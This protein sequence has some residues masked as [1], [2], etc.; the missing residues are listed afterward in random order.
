MRSF[1]AA[2]FLFCGF[3][4]LA[5]E[6][7]DYYRALKDIREENAVLA[8]VQAEIEKAGERADSGDFSDFAEGHSFSRIVRT[9]LSGASP[10]T[11]IV[12]A[13]AVCGGGGFSAAVAL[14]L[15]RE[16]RKAP[17]PLN[18]VFLFLGGEGEGASP[19]AD[20]G[21]NFPGGDHLGSRLFLD[22]FFSEYP[23]S[24]LYLNF[25]ELP[26][27]I[28]CET[29]TRGVVAPSWMLENAGAALEDSG[30]PYLIEGSKNRIYRLGLAQSLSPAGEYLSA[31]FPAL[32]LSGEGGAAA[33]D[34]GDYT[35]WGNAFQV[36]FR[37]YLPRCAD[38]FLREWDQHYL[39]LHYGSAYRIIG[40]P[41]LVLALVC[42]LGISLLYAFFAG[43]RLKRSAGIFL[44][45]IWNLP[46]ILFVSVL[47]FMAGTT[48]VRFTDALR[49]TGELWSHHPFIFFILK[50]SCAVFLILLSLHHLRRLPLS[51]RGSFYSVSA[52]FCFLVNVFLSSALD[53]TFIPFFLWSYTASV[54]FS[55]FRRPLVKIILFFTALLP[56]CIPVYDTFFVAEKD[57][58]GFVINSPFLG[59]LLLSSVFLPFILMLIRID[60]LLWHPGKAG[61]GRV[62]KT[63]CVVTG[64]ASVAAFVFALA[65]NPWK[66]SPQPLFLE[67]YVETAQSL[68]GLRLSSPSPLGRFDLSFGGENFPI[69][70]GERV[71]ELPLE[72]SGDQ[73]LGTQGSG[74]QASGEPLPHRI[75]SE[76][77]LGRKT[78][79]ILFS[80]PLKPRK[81]TVHLSCD[82]P[83]LVYNCNFPYSP[84]ITG[85]AAEVFI[86]ENPPL[87][88]RLILTF[89]ARQAVNIRLSSWSPLLSAAGGTEGKSFALESYSKLV[90]SFIIETDE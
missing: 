79:T 32:G 72:V 67:E 65:F 20:N 71:F 47:F 62:L 80:P 85:R 61:S 66:E 68:H 58:A 27:R 16:S 39:F 44:R 82:S 60:F 63:L 46:L 42:V 28:L 5:A 36:F 81:I 48:L 2:C 4:F 17:A 90:D 55:I 37:S 18:L 15:W 23:V 87:P 19:A 35:E 7:T 25:T 53:I 86:G 10:Q 14:D 43:A 26:A 29:G 51:K 22:S 33:G 64:G 70:T 52:I 8:F 73:A 78:Y 24:V 54:L 69:D 38:G 12:A 13:P 76:E 6:E 84:D 9:S 41:V 49:N 57:F 77:F 3:F 89:P 88:L 56:F 45:N 31:G 34:Y 21:G 11:L 74:D 59:N 30:L 1:F 83:L 75:S 40:E 50:T